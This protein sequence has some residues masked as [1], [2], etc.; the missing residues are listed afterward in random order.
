M[1][2]NAYT[3]YDAKALT[4]SPPFYAGAHGS[5]ARMVADLAQDPNTTV[6]RHPRDFTLY[7]VGMFNDATGTL[8]PNDIREHIADVVT[9]LPPPAATAGGLFPDGVQPGHSTS[10]NSSALK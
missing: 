10:G 6:G 9:L 8:L 3:L 2:I 1:L 4:Y 5:A 7:C